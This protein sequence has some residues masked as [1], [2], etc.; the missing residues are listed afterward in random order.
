M[1]GQE[2]QLWSITRRNGW[3]KEKV[4]LSCAFK[5]YIISKTILRNFL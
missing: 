3:F 2:G 1:L 5:A 4:L